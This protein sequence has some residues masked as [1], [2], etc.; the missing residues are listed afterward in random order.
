MQRQVSII[1]K[2]RLYPWPPDHQLCVPVPRNVQHLTNTLIQP[3]YDQPQHFGPQT[4]RR[5]TK[6]RI[7]DPNPPFLYHSTL[8]P[9]PQI[10]NPKL[11]TS[12]P[13]NRDLQTVRARLPRSKILKAV[14]LRLITLRHN[15]VTITL[16]RTGAPHS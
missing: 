11:C 2:F 8:N 16:R 5:F 4:R 7:L 10:P 1:L 14:I 3:Q 9:S 6:K 15:P 13:F 12:K